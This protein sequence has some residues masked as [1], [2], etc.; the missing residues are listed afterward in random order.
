MIFPSMSNRQ[1]L[2]NVRLEKIRSVVQIVMSQTN[3]TLMCG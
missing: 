3:F 2:K 1:L